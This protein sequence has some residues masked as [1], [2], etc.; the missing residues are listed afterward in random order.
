MATIPKDSLKNVLE[1]N[2]NGFLYTKSTKFISMVLRISFRS[3]FSWGSV[4]FEFFCVARPGPP[5]RQRQIGHHGPLSPPIGGAGGDDH[6]TAVIHGDSMEFHP[7]NWWFNGDLTKTNG[8][9]MGI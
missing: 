7:Q 4:F 8:D 1:I 5:C 6:G 9:L 3:R 2:T